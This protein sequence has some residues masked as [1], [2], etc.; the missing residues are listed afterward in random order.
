MTGNDNALRG[1]SDM[2]ASSP[3]VYDTIQ[4]LAGF[5]KVS[6]LLRSYFEEVD[7]FTLLDVGAG[8]GLYLPL[9]PAGAKYIWTDIDPQKLV[10]F[11]KRAS[12]RQKENTF[13]VMCDSLNMSIGSKSVDFAFCSAVSHH[14]ADED[15]SRLFAELARVVR[16]KLIFLDAVK[17][18]RWMSR[19][20]WAF[21]RGA[22]PRPEPVLSS[23]MEQYFDFESK[24]S[25]KIYH[26]YI[27]CTCIP[28][29]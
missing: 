11:R 17:S 13:G 16:I 26:E 21:D 28:R 19:L 18:P 29:R 9:L 22:F 25:Y 27:L 14:I 8:T 1:L 2:L 24:K 4:R 15:L 7:G 6:P 3:K 12:G 23:M 20:L 10:G 5:S